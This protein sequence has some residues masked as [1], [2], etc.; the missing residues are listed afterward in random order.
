MKDN[1]FI[2]RKLSKKESFKQFV[3]SEV[4]LLLCKLEQVNYNLNL[5]FEEFDD[6]P[7]C[8]D[9]RLFQERLSFFIDTLKSE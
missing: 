3:F 1:F 2:S 6:D 7:L 5:R 4:G 8:S 9:L